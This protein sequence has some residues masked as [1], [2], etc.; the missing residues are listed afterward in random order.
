MSLSKLIFSLDN[1]TLLVCIF[2]SSLLFAVAFS[3][4]GRQQY[5][6]QGA[7]A[8]ALGFA[9][10]ALSTVLIA[11]T[12]IVD[13]Q[14]PMARFLLTLINDGLVICFY[15][16]LLDGI[17]QFYDRSHHHRVG[18]AVTAISL[19]LLAYFTAIQDSMAARIVVVAAAIALLRGLFGFTVLLQPRRRHSLSLMMLMFGYGLLSLMQAVGTLLY[20]TPKN[21]MQSDPTQTVTLYLDLIFVLSSGLLLF[22]LLN[23]HLVLGYQAEAM[24]DFV[25]GTLNRRGIEQIL[26][27]EVERCRRHGEPLSLA[28][29]DIDHFKRLNDTQGHAA[30]DL[31][32][33]QVANL[34][35]DNL[36][37][38]DQVGRYG[39]DEF[40]LLLPSTTAERAEMILNRIRE[41]LMR[42]HTLRCTLSAGL[43]AMTPHDDMSSLLARA[44]GALYAAKTDGRDCVRVQLFDIRSPEVTSGTVKLTQ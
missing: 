27:A 25:A 42:D 4:T 15:T 19:L 10:A 41:R 28:L 40:L 17:T 23:E 33:V 35:R 30:G 21:F 29:L 31:A 11:V 6:Q 3:R 2:T 9:S 13:V 39:G 5:R 20:G 37:P 22:L 36:R 7:G 38:Y 43:T 24:R 32:L 16:L 1:Y 34:I 18:W 8:F 26:E 14:S 12:A 44:D